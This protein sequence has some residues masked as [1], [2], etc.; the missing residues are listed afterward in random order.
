LKKVK[1]VNY[2]K[3]NEIDI[4]IIDKKSYSYILGLYLGDG[5]I[6]KMKRTY[7]LRIF[8]DSRQD[9]VIKECEENLKKLF[10]DNKI[11]ILKTIYNSVI[12]SVYSNFIPI[13]FP[14]HGLNKKHE[15]NIKLE[16]FQ[17]IILISDFFMKG[18]FHSDGS[19][20]LSKNSYPRYIFTNKS[21]QI[22]EM[23]SDCLL[24]KG[25]TSRIRK[26][27]NEIYDIQ[28]Q[29]KKDVENLYPILGEKYIEKRWNN[30]SSS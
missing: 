10:P 18:L 5:Y 20:Y 14:Q 3:D 19:F 16:E 21:K 1:N 29:N 17:K 25:I 6:N 15:R 11:A 23:F 7:R 12:I 24:E 22:I 26:R 30:L 9:L 4:D 8:L 27:M 2:I 28:I 13:I